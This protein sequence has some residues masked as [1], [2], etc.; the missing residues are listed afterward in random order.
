MTILKAFKYCM[1]PSKSQQ[2]LQNKTLGCV[3]VVWNHN[4]E[5]FNKYDKN[6]ETQEQALTST[7][8]RLLVT[9]LTQHMKMR[10]ASKNS[11]FLNISCRPQQ[12]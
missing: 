2:V 7:Q 8:L 12:I 11:A 3:R 4:M 9:H 5:V 10:A 1:Y 6:L